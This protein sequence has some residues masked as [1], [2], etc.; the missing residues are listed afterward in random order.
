MMRCG[1]IFLMATAAVLVGCRDAPSGVLPVSQIAGEYELV[2]FFGQSL[3]AD[4][5]ARGTVE[6]RHVSLLADQHYTKTWKGTSCALGSCVRADGSDSGV[7]VVL[8]DG[9]VYFD[10]QAGISWPPQ[11]VE[12]NGRQLRFLIP[13]GE[14]QFTLGEV[15]ERR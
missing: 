3:P 10:S 11:R 9:T 2:R 1:P 8:A 6:S 4:N 12:A 15:Y 5:F 13:T 14:A 7:W